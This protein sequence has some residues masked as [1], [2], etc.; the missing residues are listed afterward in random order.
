MINVFL[1]FFFVDLVNNKISS[2]FCEFVMR[3][4][5]PSRIKHF[6]E[7]LPL[8]SFPQI[9]PIIQT[10]L[11]VFLYRLKFVAT[12]YRS[13]PFLKHLQHPRAFLSQTR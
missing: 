9:D 11:V 8:T 10:I 1:F 2:L 6:N 4:R 13:R 5:N 12:G 7:R 3:Y